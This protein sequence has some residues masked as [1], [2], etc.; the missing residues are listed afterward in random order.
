[1]EHPEQ[2]RGLR[3]HPE[4]IKPAVEELLRFAN[5]VE[6]A[7]ERYAKEDFVLHGTRF[8]AVIWCWRCWRRPT[9]MSRSFRSPTSWC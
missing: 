5:P 8:G 1:L 9:E 2:L 7:T 6:T 3:A 4:Q